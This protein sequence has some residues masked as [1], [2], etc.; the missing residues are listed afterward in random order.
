MAKKHKKVRGLAL[1]WGWESQ[2][3]RQGLHHLEE[4]EGL[5]PPSVPPPAWKWGQKLVLPD[6]FR[7]TQ[8]LESHC[9]AALS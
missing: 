2:W 3:G 7:L 9:R 8:I 1:A 5:Q 4:Q 6:D